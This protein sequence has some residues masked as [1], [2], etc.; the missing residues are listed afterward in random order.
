MAQEQ[1]VM[2][3]ANVWICKDHERD[4]RTVTAGCGY[5]GLYKPEIDREGFF[6]RK[7]PSCGKAVTYRDTGEV[8]RIE[9]EL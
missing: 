9:M 3:R 8:C 5:I 1:S 4:G 2:G 6:H 7:C